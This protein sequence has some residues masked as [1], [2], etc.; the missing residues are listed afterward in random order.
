MFFF[1]PETAI[2][3]PAFEKGHLETNEKGLKSPAKLAP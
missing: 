1:L 2:F 3:A